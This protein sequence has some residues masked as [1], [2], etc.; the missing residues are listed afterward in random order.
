MRSQ[1]KGMGS[2]DID[3]SMCHKI[4]TIPA[5]LH[6]ASHWQDNARGDRRKSLSTWC[7]VGRDFRRVHSVVIRQSAAEPDEPWI[8]R[9]FCPDNTLLVG[10]LGNFAVV[11][12]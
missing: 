11:E 6:C 4:R 5:L 9:A 12:Y 3:A 8:N 10:F 7:V 2:A 1:S